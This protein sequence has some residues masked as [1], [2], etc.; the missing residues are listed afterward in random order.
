[1]ELRADVRAHLA[2]IQLLKEDNRQLG[3]EVADCWVMAGF[4]VAHHRADPLPKRAR[5][6]LRQPF[7]AIQGVRTLP[8]RSLRVLSSPIEIP[9]F[10]K[11]ASN[12][13]VRGG[14]R[15]PI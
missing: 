11:C 2:G 1:M 10:R 8:S 12:G 14:M 7:R 13:C 3:Q 6:K 4:R 5:A 9:D 15:R